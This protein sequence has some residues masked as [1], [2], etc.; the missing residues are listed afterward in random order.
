MA[1]LYEELTGSIR[2]AAIEVLN[3][4]GPGLSEKCYENGLV[5]ELI[6]RG[7]IVEQQREFPVSYKGRFVG[8]R[9]PD[10]IVDRKV[11]VDTKVVDSFC[12]EHVA[13][14]LTYL[15]V[16]GLRLAL[17]VNFKRCELATK[18]VIS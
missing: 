8:K 17:L 13:Q 15:S 12:N 2:G 5:I 6:E 3:T 16:T 10:L 9:I 1:L 7:H 11:V 18:R 4:L 14:M